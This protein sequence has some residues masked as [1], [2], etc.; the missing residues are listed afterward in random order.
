MI[1]S[2]RMQAALRSGMNQEPILNDLMNVVIYGVLD[3]RSP[4][5]HFM[6]FHEQHKNTS[7]F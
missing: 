7:E 6:Q 2:L 4:I 1:D 5:C 3:F